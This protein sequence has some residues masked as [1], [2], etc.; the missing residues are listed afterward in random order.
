MPEVEE[1]FRDG[2][3]ELAAE[4]DT[5]PPVVRRV[6]ERAREGGARRRR[7]ALAGV[8]GAAAA[9]LAVVG[10]G[11]VLRGQAGDTG[12]H[13]PAASPAPP[14]VAPSVPGGYRLERWHDVGV[15]VPFTWGWGA[16]PTVVGRQGPVLC[17]AGVVQQDGARVEG[18]DLPYVGRPVAQSDVCDA[19]WVRARPRAPYVWLGGDVPVGTVDLG[20][21]WVRQTVEV[22][23][24]TVSVAAD[25]GALRR[26]ILASAHRVGGDCEPR[27]DSPPAPR[28]TTDAGFVPVT[29]TVC[30][31]APTS[32]GS[33]EDLLDEQQLSMGPAKDLVAA[34][35]RAAPLGA[36]SCFAARGGEW[37]LLRLRGTGD[38]FRD[39]V[40]DMSCPSIADPTGTQHVLDSETVTPWAVG[41]INAVLHAHPLVDAPG[42]FIPSTG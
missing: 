19:G 11:A 27:L 8:A 39:Y 24:L 26:S 40:V 28:G 14:E 5:S 3:A 25:D 6:V 34:V 23:D 37:A 4:A 31:Y 12:A 41:G 38:T 1:A 36:S 2:L 42:R 10:V 16:A 35:D 33:D 21:G 18:A 9:M 32:S 29:M 15:Y 13:R 7:S 17:G 20:G 22:G 30:A